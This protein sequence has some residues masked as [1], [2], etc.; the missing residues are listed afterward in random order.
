MPILKTGSF[1]FD[2]FLIDQNFSLKVTSSGL[3]QFW[4]FWNLG[5]FQSLQAL[6]N[7]LGNVQNITALNG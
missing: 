7:P 3:L 1:K 2:I 4:N 5:I 6:E